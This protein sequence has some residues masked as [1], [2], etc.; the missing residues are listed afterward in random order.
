MLILLNAFFASVSADAAL[1]DEVN[2]QIY[3]EKLFYIDDRLNTRYGLEVIL[4]AQAKDLK[5]PTHI[6]KQWLVKKVTA[7]GEVPVQPVYPPYDASLFRDGLLLIPKL[8]DGEKTL[9]NVKLSL[10]KKTYGH[11]AYDVVLRA[12][13]IPEDI[14]F[15]VVEW[16]VVPHL[17]QGDKGL[18]GDMGPMGDKGKPGDPGPKGDI[19]PTGPKGDTGEQGLI[20]L[21]GDPG[22]VG[23]TG[24]TSVKGDPGSAGLKGDAGSAGLRGDTGLPG[25]PGSNGVNGINGI[26]GIN[27][28]DGTD[29]LG[30]DN[31][32]R[33]VSSNSGVAL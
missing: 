8:S 31:M 6:S 4:E 23:V 33:C 15:E 27:G 29:T 18:L 5:N 30:F 11:Q 9:Y 2:Q 10:N 12:A 1:Y 7:L 28:T 3:L 32:L 26:N 20:G 13:T 21:P 17:E 14:E 19:G 24:D 22:A 25:D 16:V